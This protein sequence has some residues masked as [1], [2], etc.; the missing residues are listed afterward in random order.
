MVGVDVPEDIRRY[1]RPQ[2]GL[3]NYDCRV[4]KVNLVIFLVVWTAAHGPLDRLG[5]LRRA[6]CSLLRRKHRQT[7]TQGRQVSL[8]GLVVK[9]FGFFMHFLDCKR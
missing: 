8:R 1:Q 5:S 3:I 4:R 6:Q 9:H 2:I 7:L